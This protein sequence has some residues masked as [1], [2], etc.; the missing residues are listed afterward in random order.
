[1]PLFKKLFPA[2][3]GNKDMS[4]MRIWELDDRFEHLRGRV[5]GGMLLIGVA[6]LFGSWLA[7]KY[8]NL[9]LATIGRPATF[10]FL[11][12][13]AI[14]WFFP[15]FGALSLCWELTLQVMALFMGRDTVNLFSDWTNQTTTFWGS[16]SYTGMDSRRVLRWLA[17]LIALPI[18]LF[19]VLA[20]NMHATI[21]Q[22][23]I[24]DCGY[25]FK[26]CKVYS[27]AD[28]R[29]IT[30]IEGFR[31]RYGKLNNRAGISIDFKDGRRR[32]SAE[33]VTGKQPSIQRWLSF[34]KTERA[35]Q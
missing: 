27:L 1:M 16:A 2:G 33:W 15:G 32:S 14:W 25:A 8:T 9:A 7:L 34:S 6:F 23:E 31:N 10:R 24:R 22:N 5:I 13:T 3:H 4:Q 18:G 19:T 35:L 17:L 30:A 12:Q 21:S 26:P 11:P 29:R 20:L 28:A